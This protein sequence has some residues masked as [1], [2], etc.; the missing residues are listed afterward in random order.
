MQ[1][2]LTPAR[3]IA[4]RLRQRGEKVAIAESSAGGLIAAALRAQ[5]GASAF[6][7]GG[8]V[9]YTRQARAA[10]LGI[11]AAEMEG[12]S[13]AYLEAHKADAQGNYVLRLDY[14]SYVPFMEN[15]RSSRNSAAK[16]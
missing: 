6:F 16:F 9:V 5:P 3:A 8:A 1:G 14:P 11:T 12:V 4:E 13:A 2:L 10:L 7:L 15:A